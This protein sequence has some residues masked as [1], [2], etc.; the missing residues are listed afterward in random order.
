[1]MSA[2]KLDL[3]SSGVV[4]EQTY[5][6]TAGRCSKHAAPRHTASSMPPSRTATSL[7]LPN[8]ETAMNRSIHYHCALGSLAQFDEPIGLRLRRVKVAGFEGG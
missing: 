5:R 2:I 3:L 7:T 1:M 8:M 6:S 4:D